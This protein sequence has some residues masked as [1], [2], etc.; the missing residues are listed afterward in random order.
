MSHP[1]KIQ[2]TTSAV[3]ETILNKLEIYIFLLK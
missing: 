3:K 2:T 1:M